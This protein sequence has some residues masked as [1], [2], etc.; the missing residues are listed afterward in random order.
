MGLWQ[1]LKLILLVEL[2]WLEEFVLAHPI[3]K[4]QLTFWK[5]LG[6]ALVFIILSWDYTFLREADGVVCLPH[7]L[8]HMWVDRL[9]RLMRVAQH[10]FGVWRLLWV[11]KMAS[12]THRRKRNTDSIAWLGIN[13]AISINLLL[14]PE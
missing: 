1:V 6:S 11:L 10:Y 7:R 12:L 14:H 13:V 3:G 9:H 5:S 4:C 8:M 2:A